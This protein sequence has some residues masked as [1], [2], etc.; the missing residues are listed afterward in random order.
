[1]KGA[2]QVAC[3]TCS[4]GCVKVEGMVDP[5]WDI[6]S[7]QA[8]LVTGRPGYWL[9]ADLVTGYRQTWLQADQADLVTGRPG[10]DLFLHS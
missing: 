7:H 8:D 10:Q 9:Q 1:M 6:Y 3:F 5:C 2:L 4:T